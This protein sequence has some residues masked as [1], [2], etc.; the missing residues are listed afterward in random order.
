M[1]V[2]W[3]LAVPVILVTAYCIVM[4]WRNRQPTSLESGVA[5]FRKEME[6]LAPQVARRERRQ[7]DPP[8]G[9]PPAPPGQPSRRR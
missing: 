9:A 5:S 7:P 2:L 4:W 6:A 3:Y 1:K 8:F